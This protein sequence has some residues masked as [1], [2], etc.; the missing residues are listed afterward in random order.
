MAK[1][2]KGDITY[3]RLKLMVYLYEEEYEKA[4]VMKK[5]IIELGGNPE[6]ENINSLLHQI[7]NNIFK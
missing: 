5:W 4:E 3:L 1:G 6:I 2:S 7:K